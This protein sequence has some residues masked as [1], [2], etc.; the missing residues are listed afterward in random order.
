MESTLFFIFFRGHVKLNGF[1]LHSG[2]HLATSDCIL[3]VAVLTFEW[4]VFSVFPTAHSETVNSRSV[5]LTV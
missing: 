3:R 1:L 2:K 4:L 5:C